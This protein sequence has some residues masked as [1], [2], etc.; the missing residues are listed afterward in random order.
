[1]RDVTTKFSEALEE[2]FGDPAFKDFSF[3]TANL[4]TFTHSCEFMYDGEER[5]TYSALA[6][7][8]GHVTIHSYS[9]GAENKEIIDVSNVE[10]IK[11]AANIVL[12]FGE[13]CDY[14]RLSLNSALGMKEAFFKPSEDGKKLVPSAEPY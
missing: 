12:K 7:G 13:V 6:C 3:F 9:S 8:D 1:M 4:G 10:P 14:F 2:L 5:V 11:A